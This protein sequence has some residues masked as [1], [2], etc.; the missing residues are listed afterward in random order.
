MSVTAEYVENQAISDMLCEMG[1]DYLQG[2]FYA[3]P[4]P[5]VDK[6]TDHTIDRK[7]LRSA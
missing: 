1:V 7:M 6:L 4:E 2:Y 3:K 5:L